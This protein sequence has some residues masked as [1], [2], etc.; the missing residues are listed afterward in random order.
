MTQ[1][2]NQNAPKPYAETKKL[3]YNI[4]ETENYQSNLK[5]FSQ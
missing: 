2:I 4:F 5:E 3:V 1:I